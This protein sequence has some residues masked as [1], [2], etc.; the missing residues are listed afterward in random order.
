MSTTPKER[1][2]RIILTDDIIGREVFF[3]L[4]K[5]ETLDNTALNQFTLNKKYTI[6]D[7]NSSCLVYI[8][9]DTGRRTNA[10]VAFPCNH[11]NCITYWKL[12]RITDPSKQKK[13]KLTNGRSI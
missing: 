6:I 2:H 8:I 4:P 1:K 7:H 10:S 9:E 11:L 5:G 3:I 12:A 13:V